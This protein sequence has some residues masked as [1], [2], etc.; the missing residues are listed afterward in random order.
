MKL[1]ML[2]TYQAVDLPISLTEGEE[3][4]VNETL[5]AWLLEHRKAEKVTAR[6]YGG[7][8]EPELRADDVI[9]KEVETI[10]AVKV[11]EEEPEKIM[12]TK[13]PNRKKK[14]K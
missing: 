4:E 12:T 9:H 6:H 3:V 8:K 13:K 11:V 10:N 14:A 2:E 1:K 5:G 7:K